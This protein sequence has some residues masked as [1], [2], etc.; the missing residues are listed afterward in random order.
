MNHIN[1]KDSDELLEKII[2]FIKYKTDERTNVYIGADS[3]NIRGER[4]TQFVV[5]IVIHYSGSRG[6]KIFAIPRL[7]EPRIHSVNQRLMTEAYY[8][9]EIALKL[10]DSIGKRSLSVHLDINTNTIHKSSNVVKQAIGAVTGQ[11]LDFKVKP[12]AIAATSAADYLSNH[13]GIINSVNK[14]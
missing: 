11:G 14:F 1:E 7:V 10:K 12:N 8:A 2:D 3:K 6:S 4:A 5:A 9:M 13:P